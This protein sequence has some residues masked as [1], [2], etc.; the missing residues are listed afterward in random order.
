MSVVR[1]DSGDGR[2]HGW[3]ARAHIA[4]GHAR[5]TRFFADKACGGQHKALLGAL[6]EETRLKRQAR[7]LQ[8]DLAR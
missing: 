7:R 8:R 4:K 6:L 5:L 2:T 1:I 3:Q